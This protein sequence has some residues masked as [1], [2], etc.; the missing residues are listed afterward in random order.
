MTRADK[1]IKFIQ[2]LRCPDGAHAGEPFKLRPWQRRWIKKV[3]KTKAGKRLVRQ[4]VLSMPRKNGKTAL[5]AA[6]CLAHLCGPEAVLNG[7]L[8]SVSYERE[9]AGIVFKYLSVMVY[10]DDELSERLAVTESRKMCTDL[11]NGSVYQALSSESK[12]KHGK[13]AS[14]VVFDELAQFGSNRD[15]YD[16]MLTSCGAHD[17]PLFFVISTQARDDHAVLSELIDYGKACPD[18]E[19]FSVDVYSAPDDADPWDEVVWFK[20]NPALGDFR[21]LDEM[22]EAAQKAQAIPS[23]ESAFRN[24]YLNQRVHSSAAWISKDAW[25]RCTRKHTVGAG[26]LHA[27]LDLSSKNDLTALAWVQETPDGLVADLRAW[28]PAD[29]IAERARKDKAPYDVWVRQGFMRGVAGRVID[30][31]FVAREI[32]DINARTPFASI[33]FD[34][35]RI[36]DLRRELDA[37]GC[38]VPLHP[39]G[40]GYK[41]MAP[42]IEALED[43]IISG[44]LIHDGNPLFNMACAGAVVTTD[45]AGNRKFEKEKSNTRIDP[46]VALAMAMAAWKARHET[47]PAA[48]VYERRGIRTL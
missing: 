17:E 9:Q 46:I 42:A 26:K 3:Y 25:V 6:L 28:T 10:M 13:S 38:S 8:Y 30:Y 16:V 35:W 11:R 2:T 7:Q 12:S 34:R 27:G 15:L 19:H 39:H 1:V 23:F 22:R 29:T 36:D 24:L 14:F 20:A 33:R 5:I 43:A 44:T 45:A 18:D 4:A 32:A 41:D 31:A 21:K 40:Q 47:A 48:S 37:I